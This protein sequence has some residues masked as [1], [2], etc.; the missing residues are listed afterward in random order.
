MNNRFV[1]LFLPYIIGTV[2]LA[3]FSM[4][5]FS[6]AAFDGK[7]LGQSDVV[8]AT[9]SQAEILKYNKSEGHE[10][11]WS[12]G[13]FG[14]MPTF[15]V[16]NSGGE[17]YN[18][19]Q[20]FVYNWLKLGQSVTSSYGLLFAACF[21]F[22][23]LMMTLKIDWRLGLVGAILYGLS[24][25]HMILIEA[26]HVNKMYVLAFLAPTL[27]G[28]LLIF[29]EKYLWGAAVT[30]L[31]T[32]LQVFGNHPQITYYFFLLIGILGIAKA[33]DA[34]R[35]GQI[36][37]W[38]KSIATLVVAVVIGV[39][40]N[41]VKLWSTYEY[42]KHSIRGKNEITTDEKKAGDD[43]LTKEYAFGW[44]LGKA[45][46]FSLIAANYMGNGE[47]FV[48]DESSATFNALT[49]MPEK[50]AQQLAQGAS[51]YWGE[52]PF[53]TGNVYYGAAL[54]ML[55]FLGFYS[56][57]DS[58]KWWSLASLLFL[59]MISWGKHFS[60]VNYFL[61]DYFPMFNKFRSVNMANNLGHVI[62]VAIGMLGLQRFIWGEES[63]E[64]KQKNLIWAVGTIAS[65]LV[66]AL[67]YGSRCL[68]TPQHGGQ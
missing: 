30:A 23:L 26:G 4:V 1:K 18:Y 32:S 48:S 53:T 64:E 7:T 3:L 62:V 14:G 13:M 57:K 52:Q 67:V 6:P 66:V 33:V 31:F 51:T 2:V 35:E 47:S 55:F 50:Q 12:N 25:S 22:F 38:S 68:R 16:Y 39:L 44:S 45:E 58:L 43:G 54:M 65:L 41:I 61:F 15:Q 34:V 24:T 42:A 29:Q 46:S 8:Q 10:M 36:G 9:G 11:L 60:V 40:P 49:K 56:L 17:T 20:K 59:V 27:A 37:A 19:L 63:K 5:Y 21:G 28:I